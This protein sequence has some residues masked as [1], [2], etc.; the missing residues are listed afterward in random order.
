V[1]PRDPELARLLDAVIGAGGSYFWVGSALVVQVPEDV[2]E[3][4][5]AISERL[6]RLGVAH[7]VEIIRPFRLLRP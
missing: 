4:A 3:L 5:G 2:R 7:K 6:S 1:L